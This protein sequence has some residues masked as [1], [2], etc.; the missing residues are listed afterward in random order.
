MPACTRAERPAPAGD[1]SGEA[2]PVAPAAERPS[3]IGGAAAAGEAKS[4]GVAAGAAAP[5]S[6]WAEHITL[7]ASGQA[8]QTLTVTIAGKDGW[9][10]NTAY[11]GLKV[12]LTP[13]A[14]LTLG[15]STLDKSAVRFEAPHEGDKAERAVWE[16][17][18]SGA[19]GGIVAGRYKMVICSASTCSPPFEGRF[20]AK[21]DAPAG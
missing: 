4:A 11:P 14:G 18:V 1:G 16:V 20:E 21:V 6:P 15:Q 3:D 17:P 5:E 8:G 12:E 10:V 7:S 13:P 9:Y 19:A 2:K